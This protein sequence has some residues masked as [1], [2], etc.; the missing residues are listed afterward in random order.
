MATGFSLSCLGTP[1]ISTVLLVEVS[2]EEARA[3]SDYWK[4]LANIP[5]SFHLI[6]KNCSSHASQAFVKAGILD[7]GI[8]GLD[9]PNNLYKQLTRQKNRKVTSITGY[10]GHAPSNKPGYLSLIIHERE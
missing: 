9:T 8:P 3:F 2:T 5:N 6:G 7:R 10:I 4:Q 1:F